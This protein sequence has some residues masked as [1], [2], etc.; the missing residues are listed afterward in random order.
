MPI[1]FPTAKYRGIKIM[2]MN[3]DI[4]IE[5]EILDST[6]EKSFLLI[7]ELIDGI[8]TMLILPTTAIGTNSIGK[9]IP[10]TTPKLATA[11]ALVY[12]HRTNIDGIINVVNG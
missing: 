8:S 1:K 9:V 12:P 10:I 6:D 2:L 3:M 4:F 7:I 5:F 11:S